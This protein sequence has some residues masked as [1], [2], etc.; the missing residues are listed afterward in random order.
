MEDFELGDLSERSLWRMRAHVLRRAQNLFPKFYE[1]ASHQDAHLLDSLAVARELDYELQSR[2]EDY[3]A[4]RK[5]G[6]LAEPMIT[7]V[8][9]GTFERW[10]RK[11]GKWGGQSKMPRCSS[12][13]RIADELKAFDDLE[14]NGSDR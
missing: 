4:K 3:E 6:G 8:S 7:L 2:N 13:R 10:M 11:A 12:D 14:R 9:E 5:G 1:A